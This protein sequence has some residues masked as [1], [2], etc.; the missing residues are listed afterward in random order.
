MPANQRGPAALPAVAAHGRAADA[1]PEDAKVGA[2]PSEAVATVEAVV[3]RKD[4]TRVDY[5]VIASSNPE[6]IPLSPRPEGE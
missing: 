5:G 3:I 1:M 6:R 4:G 2:V